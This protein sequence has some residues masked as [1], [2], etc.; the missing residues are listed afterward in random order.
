M[1]VGTVYQTTYNPAS[2]GL[3]LIINGNGGSAPASV[4]AYKTSS[5]QTV[6]VSKDIP[7]T[8]PT[9]TGY[10]FLG[11]AVGSASNGVS[12][13][14]GNTMSYTFTRIPTTSTTT[15]QYLDGT[16]YVI[17]NWNCRNQAYDYNL[18][19]KWQA[20]TYTVSYNANGGTGAPAAQTKTYG[21]NLTLSSTVPTRTNYVFKGW[22]TSSS[23]TTAAYQAGGTYSANSAVTLYA[24]WEMAGSVLS[25]VTS[26]VEIGSSGSA[27]WNIL[28]AA[29]T[30]QLVVTCGS[31]PS[32]TVDVAANTSSASFTIPSSWLNAITNAASATATATLTTYNSGSAMGSSYL[33]FTVTVPSSVVPTISSFTA[34]H[35]SSNATVAGWAAFTQGYSQADLSVSAT[36]GTGASIA[37][38]AFTGPSV[39]Q[40]GDLLAVRTGILSSPGTNTFTVTITDSRGRSASDTVPVTVYPYASPTIISIETMRANA[41]GTTN[42]SSGAYM[43]V[44]PI[45]SLSSVNSNN[46]FTAQTLSYCAHGAG[47]PVATITC[48]SGTYYGP[49]GTLWAINQAD[50]YDVTVSV[51]DALGNTATITVTLPGTSGIWYGRTNDRLGLGDAPDGPG[52]WSSWDAYFKGVVD[53]IPRRVSKQI[54]SSGWFR[55]LE[56][57]AGNLAEA[58]GAIGFDI[59]L[60]IGKDGIGSEA[61]KISLYGVYGKIAF[62]DE[63]ST[64][65]TQYI[66]KIR[67]TYE[68]SSPNSA[69]VDIHLSSN[70]QSV[71]TVDFDVNVKPSSQQYFKAL[72]LD[73]VA[74]TPSG[75]TVL[76]TYLLSANTPSSGSGYQMLADGTMLQ[77]GEKNGISFSATNM[78]SGSIQM[79]KSFVDT[80]Y[81]VVASPLTTGVNQYLFRLGVNPNTADTFDWVLGSGDSSNITI[82]GRGFKWIA[83]GRWKQ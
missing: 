47:T 39:N 60:T 78:V 2:Y 33:P 69:Y 42:N 35:Y 49:P 75:E 51:T 61:H 25:T 12:K 56:Y 80:N 64:S 26:S 72:A 41:D 13:Q 36:A 18:Y 11:Y 37:S 77:W 23:A 28:D 82:T 34:T 74:D 53:V 16:T 81:V 1:A 50:A 38:V 22:A 29:F 30:Y 8:A 62:K 14:P 54:T 66:D 17:T 15:T 5:S 76:T 3:N 59:D 4:S 32:V 20:N 19:A 6:T 73:S 9:R 63:S 45:Y 31:A 24:V 83:I 55:V 44:R 58:Q 68:N 79:T 67:Y 57:A 70:P 65:Q 7:S 46:S 43:K 40:N 48:A 27:S 10:T 52:M 71:V 21:V